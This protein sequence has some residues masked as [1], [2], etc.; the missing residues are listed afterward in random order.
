MPT[1]INR[2]E[3]EMKNAMRAKFSQNEELK[4]LLLQTKDAKLVH[5]VRASPPAVFINLMEIRQELRGRRMRYSY[6]DTEDE[7]ED[8]DED[9]DEDDTDEDE[10]EDDTDEDEDE[11]EDTD[12]EE[13]EEEDTDEDEDDTDEEED[14][15]EDEDEDKEN[16]FNFFST[17]CANC[18][19]KI[20]DMAIKTIKMNGDQPKMVVYCCTSCYSTH[21]NE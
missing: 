21:F 6:N 18:N 8:T 16:R 12:E 11:E 7:E 4:H 1:L 20:E 10:D 3:V 15:D 19:E 14:T 2:H 17:T 5:Y 9:E 13:D